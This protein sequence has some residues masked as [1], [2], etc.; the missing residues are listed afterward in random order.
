LE[1]TKVRS[2]DRGAVRLNGLS[3][4]GH[5]EP[6]GHTKYYFIL[7]AMRRHQ[8]FWFLVLVFG[9]D[10]IPLVFL[11]LPEMDWKKREELW[12]ESGRMPGQRVERNGRECSLFPMPDA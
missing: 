5:A 10:G 3:G 12:Q 6:E 4:P 7:R 2:C 11:W 1:L 8:G 9:G